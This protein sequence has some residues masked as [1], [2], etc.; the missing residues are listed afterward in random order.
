MPHW[1][2]TPAADGTWKVAM[3]LDLGRFSARSR[4]AAATLAACPT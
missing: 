1:L 4:V 2:V 3:R